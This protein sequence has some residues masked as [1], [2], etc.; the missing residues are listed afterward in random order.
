MGA[1][2]RHGGSSKPDVIRA[3]GSKETQI[4]VSASTESVW[5]K[6]H[7]LLWH[8]LPGDSQGSPMESLA[9]LTSTK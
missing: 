2:N 7:V 9:P 5:P 1:Q 4:P 8:K 6:G 3:D